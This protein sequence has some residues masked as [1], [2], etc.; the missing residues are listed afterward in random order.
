MSRS[1]LLMF[2]SDLTLY[3][4]PVKMWEWVRW[5]QLWFQRDSNDPKSCAIRDT[6]SSTWRPCTTP[7][8]QWDYYLFWSACTLTIRPRYL[9]NK[10]TLMDIEDIEDILIYYCTY[11]FQKSCSIKI[12]DVVIIYTYTGIHQDDI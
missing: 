2:K 11:S 10:L 6:N 5:P 8:R 12:V 1:R 9:T 7:N 4:C 3:L